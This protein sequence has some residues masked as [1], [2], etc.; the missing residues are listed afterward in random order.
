[1]DG[2]PRAAIFGGC[3]AGGRTEGGGGGC[4]PRSAPRARPISKEK[5]TVGMVICSN[6]FGIACNYSGLII[7]AT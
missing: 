3:P 5:R 1:M 6:I 2:P 7:I 4:L